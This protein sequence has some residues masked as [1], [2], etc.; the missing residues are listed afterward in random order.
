MIFLSQKITQ[1]RDEGQK[2]T[3]HK[4]YGQ[5]VLRSPIFTSLSIKF[6]GHKLA[7]RL[8]MTNETFY[9]QLTEHPMYG[10][11]LDPKIKR[12]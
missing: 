4:K 7:A 1:K 6:S 10:T 11:R 3:E 12:D 8:D 2:A 9:T 5:S